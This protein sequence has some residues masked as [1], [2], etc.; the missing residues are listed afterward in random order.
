[1]HQALAGVLSSQ[2]K[3]QGSINSLE[4]KATQLQQKVEST[5]QALAKEREAVPHPSMHPTNDASGNPGGG[6]MP[7]QAADSSVEDMKDHSCPPSTDYPTDQVSA[8]GQAH[9]RA[10][11]HA[12]GAVNSQLG[13]LEQQGAAVAHTTRHSHAAH[14]RRSFVAQE[15]RMAVP[16]DAPRGRDA[17]LA[18]NVAH[19]DAA[20]AALSAPEGHAGAN[21]TDAKESL[22]HSENLPGVRGA[23]IGLPGEGGA[24]VGAS[25]LDALSWGSESL[26]SVAGLADGGAVISMTA[27]DWKGKRLDT[28]Q[29]GHVLVESFPPGTHAGEQAASNYEGVQS[30]LT[31][32]PP[33]ESTITNSMH[34]ISYSSPEK[35]L[36]SVSGSSNQA[37]EETNED[38]KDANGSLGWLQKRTHKLPWQE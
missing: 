10:E 27:A 33:P 32:P 22:N 17:R 16:T 1:M 14:V 8:S 26:D 15:N 4:S 23:G 12:L 37:E 2:E 25:H 36:H 9:P 24:Q 34:N 6:V 31:K 7:L 11:K 29:N 28:S 3:A 18:N 35:P 21:G 5:E 20:N 13:D 30:V 19:P 38:D